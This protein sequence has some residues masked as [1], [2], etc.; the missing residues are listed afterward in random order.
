MMH[1]VIRNGQDALH[2]IG[3]VD[4]YIIESLRDHTRAMGRD[5]ALSLEIDVNP[6]D[7]E[8]LTRQVGTWLD[9][10]TR[11]GASVVVRERANSAADAPDSTRFGG[12]RSLDDTRAIGHPPPA[13]P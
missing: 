13:K 9:R 7:A 12:S 11:R 10:L 5:G 1:A 6:N 8:R 3:H 2:L 4:A